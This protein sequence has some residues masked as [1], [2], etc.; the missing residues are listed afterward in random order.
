MIPITWPEFANIHPFAPIKQAQGYMEMIGGLNS[1]LAGI[2][3]FVA[4]ST[5]PNVR[6]S[7]AFHGS[8]ELMCTCFLG[9]T[10]WC[11]R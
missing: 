6:P 3:Q 7:L 4:A 8:F 5:Q 1:A 11:P 9:V 10:V 2:T